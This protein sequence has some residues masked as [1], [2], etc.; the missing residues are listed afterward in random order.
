MS[1]EIKIK[2]KTIKN[3]SYFVIGILVLLFLFWPTQN[4]EDYNQPDKYNQIILDESENTGNE[5]NEDNFD[6]IEEL[7][8]GKIPITYK[9]E[10]ENTERQLNL[11]RNAFSKIEEETGGIVTF[12]EVSENPDISIY[13]K[14]SEY[15][16]GSEHTVADALISEV[17]DSRN[18]ILRGE[19][20][21]YGQ[22]FVCNTG[23]P[24]LE[25]HEILHLFDIPHN[26]LTKSIMSPYTAE[27][28]S[29]CEITEIDSE[30][31]SCLRYIYSNGEIEGN[32]DFPNVI[33]EKEPE[34]VCDEGWYPVAG[35]DYCCPEPNM[36]IVDDYCEY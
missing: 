36:R 10:N 16:S 3:V 6:K 20:N 15:N 33:H 27:S 4:N 29:R 32:C 26:P 2:K 18:L 21:F 19:L 28:S 8:W 34:Y 23:Y 12:E 24:A 1:N 17:D 35:T 22:G 31:I 5:L 7:H 9:F 30:Y 11:T 25:V 13:F 14:S